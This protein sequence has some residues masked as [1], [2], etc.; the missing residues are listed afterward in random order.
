M[1]KLACGINKPNKQTILPMDSV[2][3]LFNR[4]KIGKMYACNKDLIL[5]LLKKNSF[6]YKF[7]IYVLTIVNLY[8]ICF[9]SKF[10]K[11]QKQIM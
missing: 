3:Q 6:I 4:I 1:S 2:S 7:E 10:V 9:L 8:N 11:A 5:M